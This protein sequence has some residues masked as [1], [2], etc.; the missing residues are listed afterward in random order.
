[1]KTKSE[2]LKLFQEANSLRESIRMDL[3]NKAN[4]HNAVLKESDLKSHD[5][6]KVHNNQINADHK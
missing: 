5:T 4:N 1:M 3:H 6:F 2:N